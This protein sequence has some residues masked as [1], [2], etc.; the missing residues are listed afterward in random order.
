MVL[1]LHDQETGEW[2]GLPY[3]I[4]NADENLDVMFTL[5]AQG[6]SEGAGITTGPLF[7][8]DVPTNSD[9]EGGGWN[10]GGTILSGEGVEANLTL[11]ETSEGLGKELYIGSGGGGEVSVGGGWGYSWRITDLIFPN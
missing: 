4:V 3:A 7:L 10:L 1:S 8:W 6:L 11:C 5:G 9:L 2:K